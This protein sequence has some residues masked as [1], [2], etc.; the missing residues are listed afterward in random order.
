MKFLRKLGFIYFFYLFIYSGLEFTLTF[1]LYREFDMEP[2]DVG[3]IFCGIGITMA[4]LQGG[5]VR[6]IPSESIRTF[7]LLVSEIIRRW[8]PIGRIIEYD[9]FS[10]ITSNYSFILFRWLGSEKQI[11]IV[12]RCIP[13]FSRWVKYSFIFEHFYTFFIQIWTIFRSYVICSSMYD[14][15]GIELWYSFSERNRVGYFQIF[16]ILRQSSGSGYNVDR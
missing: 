10:G 13:L 4:A 1:L 15:F 3:Y 11:F 6:K 7:A 2:K 8:N 5:F 12:V 16:R 14:Y 9:F